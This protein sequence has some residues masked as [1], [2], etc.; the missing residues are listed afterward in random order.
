MASRHHAAREAAGGRPGIYRALSVLHEP[1]GR[2]Q[3]GGWEW[4]GNHWLENTT[5]R[6]PSPITASKGLLL[7]SQTL[8]VLSFLSLLLRVLPPAMSL[9]SCRADS[10][11]DVPLTCSL[12]FTLSVF[13]A[14]FFPLGVC[15][16]GLLH[17]LCQMPPPPGVFSSLHDSMGVLLIPIPRALCLLFS[18]RFP[19]L[20]SVGH[21]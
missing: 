4:E 5:L 2:R 14:S 12:H 1:W 3:F 7:A 19:V 21:G 20:F 13:A 10:L 17:G 18:W 11:L 8:A 9:Y 16:L 6:V 15:L